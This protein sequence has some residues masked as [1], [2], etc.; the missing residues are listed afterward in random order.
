M[1][2]ATKEAPAVG[3][4][5]ERPTNGRAVAEG[6]VSALVKLAIEEKV[7]VEV[8][9]RLVALQERVADRAAESAMNDAVRRF[10]EACPLLRKSRTA[11]I[12]TKSGASYAY[13]YAPLAEI[14]DTIRD[15]L[16]ECGLSYTWDSKVDAGLISVTCTLYHV[17]GARRTA[18]FTGPTASNSG[19][20]EIQKSGA[21]LTY[22]R[23]Q[24]LVQVLGLT[25]AD[26]DRDG[27]DPEP[28]PE[29]ITSEQ[30]ADLDALYDEVKA[31]VNAKK[32]LGFFGISKLADMPAHR[33]AEAVKMLERKR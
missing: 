8:L 32:F 11:K 21:A 30:L 33:Y 31:A 27:A 5:I 24:A 9:E 3:T 25:Q 28:E 15:L 23:R 18:T 20:S 22:G 2:T 17:D 1:T 19:A 16:G 6:E 26:E 13:T 14:V 29:P 10:Q 7:S 12:A 4:A